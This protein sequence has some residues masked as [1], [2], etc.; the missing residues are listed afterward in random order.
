MDNWLLTM[1]SRS[2]NEEWIVISKL[3]PE[4]LDICM[5]NEIVCLCNTTY[6]Y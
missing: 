2:F 6:K 5:E 1:I 4:Q 3:A